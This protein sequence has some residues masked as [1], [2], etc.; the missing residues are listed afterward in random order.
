METFKKV[1]VKVMVIG[2]SK[3]K[4]LTSRLPKANT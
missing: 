2:G 3:V 1:P 4:V